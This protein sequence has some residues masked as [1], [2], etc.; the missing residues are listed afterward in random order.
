MDSSIAFETMNGI[1]TSENESAMAKE[2]NFMQNLNDNDIENLLNTDPLDDVSEE[3]KDDKKEF[4]IELNPTKTTGAN[5][6]LYNMRNHKKLEKHNYEHEKQVKNQS[7]KQKTDNKEAMMKAEKIFNTIHDY[8]RENLSVSY[9]LLDKHI[10]ELIDPDATV[11]P[12]LKYFNDLARHSNFKLPSVAMLEFDQKFFKKYVERL[13]KA[14]QVEIKWVRE[15][16]VL[17]TRKTLQDAFDESRK[18]L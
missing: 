9:N 2:E 14:Q 7:A 11:S 17:E 3:P 4:A 5:Q 10:E 12:L 18:L 8:C 16:V 6:S 15:S 13:R 1:T